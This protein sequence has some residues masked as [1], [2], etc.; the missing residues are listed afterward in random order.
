MMLPGMQ[1]ALHIFCSG[2]YMSDFAEKKSNAESFY[3]WCRFKNFAM[4]FFWYKFTLKLKAFHTCINTS[5]PCGISR[6]FFWHI[7]SNLSR[8]AGGMENPQINIQLNGFSANFLD[9]KYSLRDNF[10]CSLDV[11]TKI[12]NFPISYQNGKYC[13]IGTVQIFQ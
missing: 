5:S 13:R 10:Y 7:D 1:N 3:G 2:T 6:I 12:R 9:N 4:Q 8:N 11:V